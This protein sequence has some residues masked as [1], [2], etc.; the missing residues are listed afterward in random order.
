[1]VSYAV[2]K[3]SIRSRFDVIESL[4]LPLVVNFRGKSL[5][6]LHDLRGL[7][8][9]HFLKRLGYR[10]VFWL[11]ARL[12]SATIAVSDSTRADIQDAL[13][14]AA[15]IVIGNTISET[16]NSP[17]KCSGLNQH[18]TKYDLS[19]KFIVAVGH[20]E[21]RKNY[22]NLLYAVHYLRE[23]EFSPQVV[24]IGN[25]SGT[26]ARLLETRSNL[27]LQDNVKILQGLSDY[28]IRLC[29][30]LASGFIFPSR[31]E[32]FGIP[33]LEAMNANLP[34]ALSNLKVF[35]EVAGEAA[36]YFDPLNP[37]EI[38]ES[39]VKLDS[40]PK[41]SETPLPGYRQILARYDAHAL[42]KLLADCYENMASTK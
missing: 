41:Q 11:S 37:V 4:S 20:F 27:A 16:V 18:I 29:Y 30:R 6:T 32:G 19:E 28:E 14:G 38:A 15:V 23:R 21:P 17:I 26:L 12:S 33:I 8:E 2:L 36:I 34:M 22:E 1:M 9:G 25:D 31:Y 42:S 10:V 40:I 39:I 7:S 13:P 3:H 24:I 35:R 5:L